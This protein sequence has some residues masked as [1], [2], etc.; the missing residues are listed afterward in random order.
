MAVAAQL[1]LC[2]LNR[3]LVG[4]G[5]AVE[6]TETTCAIAGPQTAPRPACLALWRTAAHALTTHR[7]NFSHCCTYACCS[8]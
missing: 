3:Q 1:Q 2:L 8:R 4:K 7:V 6:W 5:L